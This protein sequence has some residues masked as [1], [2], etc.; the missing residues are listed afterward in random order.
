[1]LCVRSEN[2]K[3]AVLDIFT[4]RDIVGKDSIAGEPIHTA[5][6]SALTD[7]VLLQIQKKTMMRALAREVSLSNLFWLIGCEGTCSTSRTWW[8]SAAISAR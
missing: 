1:L 3:Q 5:S 6:T 2:Q 4:E 8:I 7:C